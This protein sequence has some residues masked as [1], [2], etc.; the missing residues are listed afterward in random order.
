MA[1]DKFQR[2]RLKIDPA[3]EVVKYALRPA[4]HVALERYYQAFL[5]CNKAHVLMLAKQNIISKAAEKAILAVNDEMAK[6]GDRPTF[7]IDPNKEEIYFNL[8][9]YLIKKTGIE[10]GGQ[11]HTARSRNDLNYTSWRLATRNAFF[12]ICDLVNKLRQTIID[13][14]NQNK[15]A[16]MSG[17][18]HL[19]PSEPITFAHYCSAISACLER[20]FHRLKGCYITINENSLGGTSMG[21]TTFP[22]DRE[23]TTEL[24]GF[25]RPVQNSLDCVASTDF[26]LE[27]L[28]AMAILNNTLCR[29]CNDLYVWATPDYGYLEIHDSCACI[30]SIMPQKKNPWTLEYIK[31]KTATAQGLFA[32]GMGTSRTMPYTF[33]MEFTEILA[34]LWDSVQTTKASVDMLNVTLRTL[35]VNKERM[36]KTAEGNYC[37]VTELANALVRHDKISFRAAHRIVAKVV[38]HMLEHKLLANQIDTKVVNIYFQELFGK[39]TIMEE[40]DLQEALDPKMNCYSKKYL[41][42]PAPEEVQRQLNHLQALLDKDKQLTEERRENVAKAKARLEELVSQEINS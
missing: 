31:G 17:Y 16:V 33:C 6:M 13:F 35:K 20:D 23:M 28:A 7:E 24:L 26:A 29:I 27:F 11:Q 8:E 38:N 15:D 40:R 9:T 25:D 1:E 36:L 42:G 14:A 21:S 18:T 22:I 5:D 19:Q 4:L 34:N 30:S 2:G 3:P 41:G 32:S 39:D 10:I 12:E 37:T